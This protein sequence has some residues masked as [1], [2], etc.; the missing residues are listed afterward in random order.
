MTEPQPP[1]P[2]APG[3]GQPPYPPPYPPYGYQPPINMY[4]ILALVLGAAVFPPLGIYFGYKAKEQ[5]AQTGER[6]TELATA[7]LV[8]GWIFTA[9]YAVFMVIWCGFASTIFFGGFGAGDN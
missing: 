2:S 6:G 3:T 7:G 1:E 5:I 4:A 9:L 8:I